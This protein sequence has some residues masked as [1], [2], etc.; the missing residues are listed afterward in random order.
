MKQ[1]KAKKAA[2]DEKLVPAVKRV[3]IGLSNLR[4]DPTITQ[5]EE[6]FQVALDILKHTLFYNAFLISADVPEIYMQQKILDISPRVENQE[7]TEPP[8]T[9]DLKAFVLKLGY[10]GNLSTVAEMYA[11]HMHQPWRTFGAIIN[12]CLS[13]KT[14]ANDRLHQSRL[15]IL[16]GMFHKANVDYATMLWEDLKYQNNYRQTEVKRR[17]LMPYPWFT[18]VI[19][20]HFMSK[21]KSISKRE[22]SK[23][24]ITK[25]D[26]LLERLKFISKGRAVKEDI[27]EKPTKPKKQPSKKKL[28]LQDEP[29][30]SE[31]EHRPVSKKIQTARAVVIREPFSVP[32]KQTEESLGKLKGIELLSKTSLFDLDTKRAIMESQRE[33]RTKHKMESSSEATGTAPG[34]PNELSGRAKVSDEGAGITREVS[35]ETKDKSDEEVESEDWGLIDYEDLILKE[36]KEKL[37]Q[38][39]DDIPWVSSNDDESD[40][41]EDEESNAERDESDEEKSVDIKKTDEEKTESDDDEKEVKKVEMPEEKKVD[42]EQKDEEVHE[43]VEQTMD[44]QVE[45]F[46]EMEQFF[47]ELKEADFGKRIHDLIKSQ[48]PSVV[49]Q[50]LGTRLPDA[51]HKE[52]QTHTANL[53]KELSELNYKEIIEESVKAQVVKE[54]NNIL[55]QLLLKAVSD[56][57]TPVIQESVT[58][59][60]RTEIKTQLP[61]ILPEAISDVAAPMIQEEFS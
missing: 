11:D 7:F 43:G 44:E 50:Y 25:E 22:G 19:I 58:A 12:K 60:V 15:E 9:E 52:L 29:S 48:L 10:G 49:E 34:V 56:F 21:H 17:E 30:N 14:V 36:D 2:L 32:T 16:W 46:S 42:E 47:K 20:Q 61:M 13:G 6:T 45:R 39:A 59:T 5:Q 1:D 27:T 31:E 24:H 40:A 33:R 23:Y 35:D 26:G 53:K 8:T 41:E 4:I 18:K 55:P 57:S 54:V 51:F 3:K 28:Q 37:K 38:K